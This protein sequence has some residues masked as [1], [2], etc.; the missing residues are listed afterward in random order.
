MGK[1]RENIPRKKSCE[2]D[3]HLYYSQHLKSRYLSNWIIFAAICLSVP[4]IGAIAIFGTFFS[5]RFTFMYLF[6]YDV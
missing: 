4:L 6:L 5:P 3:I 1:T 2:D